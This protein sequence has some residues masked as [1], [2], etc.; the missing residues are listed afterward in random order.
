[1]NNESLEKA[2]FLSKNRFCI[3]VFFYVL[4]LG[5]FI[6]KLFL[7]YLFPQMHWGHGLLKGF[8][9]IAF[10]EWGIGILGDVKALGLRGWMLSPPHQDL[11]PAGV[12]AI[13]YYIF[14]P[15]PY[16][17]LPL[18]AIMHAFS[19]WLLWSIFERL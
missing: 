14:T 1:M 10:H 3:Y 7:P 6:Q 4:I 11:Q 16:V 15:E 13:F 18:N 5:L 19:V 2:K 12:A 17:L 8:D 9:S